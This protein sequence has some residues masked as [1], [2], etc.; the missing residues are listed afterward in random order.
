MGVTGLVRTEPLAVAV[1]RLRVLLLTA[2]A[3]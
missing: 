3:V 2:V 1:V